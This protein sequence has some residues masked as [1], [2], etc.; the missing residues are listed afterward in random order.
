[1]D[2]SIWNHKQQVMSITEEN[3]QLG[4]IRMLLIQILSQKT[5]IWKQEAILELQIPHF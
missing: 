4:R 1:M 5:L 2:I 3:H